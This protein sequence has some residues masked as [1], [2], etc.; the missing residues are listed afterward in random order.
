M[1]ATR[2]LIP[3]VL[4]ALVALMVPP[5]ALTAGAR[6][7]IRP[8]G[9]K[10]QLQKLDNSPFSAG[11]RLDSKQ[12]EP[13]EPYVPQSTCVPFEQPGVAAFRTLA[14]KVYPRSSF[15][16]NNYNIQRAC[17]VPG[18][19]EHLE[20]RAFDFKADIH[21]RWQRLQAQAFLDW[22]TADEGAQAKRFGIMYM[23][24]NQ[25]VWNQESQSWRLMEDRGDD[26]A[27]HRDHIHFSFTW[28]GALKRTSYWTGETPPTDYGP[29][30][31]YLN[32]L[33]AWPSLQ[34]NRAPNV[35]PCVE[36]E[37]IPAQLRNFTPIIPGQSSD[38][39]NR[40]QRFLQRQDFGGQVSGYY[41]S[42]TYLAVRRFQKA[43]DIAPT[44]VWDRITQAATGRRF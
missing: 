33:A 36:P 13:A 10:A 14:Y 17:S 22:L 23:I 24:W 15:E 44:G 2:L 28:N 29:C 34:P 7:F 26:T 42:D 41:W 12:P 30:R 4:I 35:E 39:V 21:V 11:K 18:V 3:T 43:R 5:L 9:T 38:R 31:P 8:E 25:H 27:N 37:P 32:L 40:L 6:P 16:K 1:R 20:G 19:S